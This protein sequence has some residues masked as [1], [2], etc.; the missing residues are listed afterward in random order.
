MHKD[1]ACSIVYY[2]GEQCSRI[3]KCLETLITWSAWRTLQH[4]KLTTR[5]DPKMITL[6]FLM[7]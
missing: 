2:S 5:K 3:I 1:A 4:G 7:H 6:V